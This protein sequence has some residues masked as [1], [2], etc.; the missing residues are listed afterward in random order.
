MEKSYYKDFFILEKAHWL[1][2]VRRKILLYFIEKYSRVGSTIFDFGCGSGYLV[3]ELQHLGYD[4]HGADFEKD[5]IDYGMN[6][7]VKNLK[8]AVGEKIDYPDATFDTVTAFDVLEHINDE[9]P[10]IGEFIRILKPGGRLIVTVPAYQWLWGV[11]DEVSHHFR[12]YNMSS[13][14]RVFNNF[15]GLKILRKTYF[16]TL[17]FSPIAIVRLVSRWFNV[18]SRKS[19]F[20]LSHP[21]ID[22]IF[23]FI[24]NLESHLLKF[25]D[26]PFGVS[27]VLIL[28]KK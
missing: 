13:L 5:A 21:V 20:E 14:V 9:R 23:Y 11:Q 8:L 4:A 16:N 22:S 19:D 7:D 6:N 26:F 18:K 3:G 12:R 28:E 1:F 2:K 25:S 15:Q 27:I 17:L 10:V 24:F